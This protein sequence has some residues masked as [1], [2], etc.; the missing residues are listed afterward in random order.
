MFLDHRGGSPND[1][2]WSSRFCPKWYLHHCKQSQM[3]KKFSPGK[4]Q[5]WSETC[6][7]ASLV[8][9]KPW[10]FR[11][12]IAFSFGFFWGELVCWI[13]F[14]LDFGEVIFLL[15]YFSLSIFLRWVSLLKFF[16]LKFWWGI[17]FYSHIFSLDFSEGLIC[18]IFSPLDFGE[19]IFF[20][21]YSLFGFFWGGLV[22]CN[23]FSLRFW[24]GNVFYS[25]FFSLDFSEVS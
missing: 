24:W 9:L 16:T 25:H 19:V 15:T 18:W 20:L 21:T 1:T 23:F 7:L 13:F 12:F 17:F 22:C 10:P 11:K 6:S 5:L 14:P 3:M 2:P 4:W 8:S